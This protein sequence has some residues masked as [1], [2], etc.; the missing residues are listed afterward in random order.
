MFTILRQRNF[1]LLWWGQLISAIGDWMLR[2]ALPI[3]VYDQTGSALG[4]GTMFIVQTLPRV[5]FGSLAGVFVDRWNRK[6]TMVISDLA[7]TVLVLLL[8]IGSSPERLW[9]IYLV[10]FVQSTISQ[11][12]GPAKEAIIPH[13]VAEPQLVAANSL[14]ALSQAL[15]FL[16]GPSLGGV[17]MELLGMSSVVLLNSASFLVSGAMISLISVSSYPPEQYFKTADPGTTVT[18]TWTTM[19]QEWLGG[20]RLV[21][22]EFWL[23]SLFI[24]MGVAA[25]AQGIINV[26]FVIFVREVLKAGALEFGWLVAIQGIGGLIG[27]FIVGQVG[28]S[29]QPSRLIIL[30]ELMVGL[31]FVTI[32]SFPSLL[33]ALILSALLAIPATGYQ[34]GTQTLLQ[35]KVADRYRGRIFGTRDTTSALLMLGGLGLASVLGDVLGAMLILKVAGGLFFFAGVIALVLLRRDPGS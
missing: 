7:Q 6:R 28:K 3:Y 16:I 25:F 15:I 26:L 11:F 19:W 4:I 8:L 23:I 24:V 34:V 14:N 18:A 27:G 35:S 2:I 31:I 10:A 30:G 29:L 12:F 17:V 32:F 5:L 33:L 22:R 9:V 21:K 13:L 1:A 20:L